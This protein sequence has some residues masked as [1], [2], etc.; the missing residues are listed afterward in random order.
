MTLPSNFV[1]RLNA[2]TEVIDDGAALIGGSPTRY[3][4]LSAA[5]QKALQYREVSAST[6][7]GA[8]LA[9]RLLDLGMADPVLESL[10]S[11]DTEYTIVVPVR[12]RVASLER[13]LTSV[14]ESVGASTSDATGSHPRI[15]VVDDASINP[16]ETARVA[17]AFGAEVVALET[18]LGPAGARNTGLALVNTEFVV[19]LDSDLVINEATIPTLLKHFADPRVALVAPRI[20]SLTR[21]TSW[22]ARYEETNSSLDLGATASAVRPRSKMSWVSS[23]VLAARTATLGHGFDPNMRIAEDVDLVWRLSKQGWRIR[24]EPSAAAHHEHRADF[25]SWF[26]RRHQ[27]GTGAVPLAKRHPEAIAPAILAPW[28]IGVML[29]LLVQRKWSIPLALGIAAWAAI[30][31]AGRLGSAQDAL[32]LSARLTARGVGSAYTQTSALVLKHW[33][34]FTLVGC[35]L[36]RRIRRATLILALADVG[37]DFVRKK[38]RLDPVRFGVAKRL[39]DIAY[40]SGVWLASLRAGTFA[41]LKPEVTR[42]EK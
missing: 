12:D 28:G 25:S 7:V 1:V 20:E 6:K 14:V 35:L 9:D 40:G 31:G 37:L 8:D 2:Q 23:S 39:D 22:I 3:V 19:F 32:S 15:V 16:E 17:R 21:S 27:Y 29:A 42:P 4:R 36:S 30:Q 41:A 34:P 13:L 38:P 11:L 26:A 24:Y 33:W 18:N 5:A 10:E